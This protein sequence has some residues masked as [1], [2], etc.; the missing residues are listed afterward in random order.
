M[1]CDVLRLPNGEVL[2]ACS[3]GR[4]KKAPPCA[5]CGRPSTKQC[6]YLLRGKKAVK[7]CD[8]HLCD[9]CAVVQATEDGD[10]VDFCKAHPVRLPLE[11]APAPV[12]GEQL[13]LL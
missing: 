9:A 11:L 8:R 7:T 12:D 5:D 3:R 1:T 4:R 10:T 13:T 6:D 2:I